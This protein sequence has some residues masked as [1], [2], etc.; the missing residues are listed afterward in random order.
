MTRRRGRGRGGGFVPCSFSTTEARRNIV[1]NIAA[2]H[3]NGNRSLALER[4]VDLL[5]AESKG[6][7]SEKPAP[8]KKKQ[9]G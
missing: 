5:V 8:K 7:I 2:K 1:D 3:F 4:A 9:R 6:R